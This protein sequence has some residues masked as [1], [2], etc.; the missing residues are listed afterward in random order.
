MHALQKLVFIY[1]FLD[2]KISM[3][4]NFTKFLMYKEIHFKLSKE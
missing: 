4:I 3:E 1:I 2:N